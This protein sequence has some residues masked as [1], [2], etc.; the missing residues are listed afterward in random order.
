MSYFNPKIYNKQNLKDEDRQEI[1]FYFGVIDNALRCADNDAEYD[2][3]KLPDSVKVLTRDIERDYLNRIKQ[4]IENQFLVLVVSTI[5]SADIED[6][7]EQ[8]EPEQFRFEE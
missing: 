8:E 7:K 2:A 3:D 1:E 4:A 5:E 6:I